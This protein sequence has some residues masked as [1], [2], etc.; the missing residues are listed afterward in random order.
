MYTNPTIIRTDIRITMDTKTDD[1]WSN[2]HISQ[3]AWPAATLFAR[4]SLAAGFL[5]ATAD[6]FGLWGPPGTVNVFWGNFEGFKGNVVV[7]APYLSTTLVNVVAWGAS[8]LELVF[9]VALLLGVALR[10]VSVA[11]A[12]TL[13]AYGMSMVFNMG[14]Q[15]VFNYA[16]FTAASAALLLSLAPT[17]GYAFSIDRWM[18]ARR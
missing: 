12:A 11:S 1:I 2:L 16:I 5:S 9:A 4:A 3:G 6:R 8:V 14:I 10:Y 7:L 17:S 13:V 18:R 15:S